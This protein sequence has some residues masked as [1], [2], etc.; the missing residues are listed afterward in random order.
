MIDFRYHL[1]SLISV[2]LALAVGIALGAGPLEESIGNTL[3]GQVD[4]LREERADLR[5]QLEQAEADLTRS[6][7]ALD[8]VSGDLLAEVMGQRRVALVQVA[9]VEP[10]VRDAVIARLEQA[11]ATVSA[12]VQV[13]DAW[14][15]PAELAFRQSLA[16]RLVEY[17]D[18][19]PAD[20]AGT[21]TELAEA[22]AQGLTAARPEDPDAVAESAAVVLELLRE[23]GLIEVAADVTAPADAVVVLAGPAVSAVQAEQEQEQADQETVEPEVLQQEDEL[24]ESRLGAAQQI[25]TAVQLRSAGAVVAGGDLVEPSLVQRLRADDATVGLVSTVESVQRVSGQV[26]VPLALA[27]RISGV[28]GHYGTSE[29][30]TDLMPPRV[31]LPPV[32]RVPQAPAEE[33]AAPDGG[34]EEPPTEGASTGDGGSTGDGEG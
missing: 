12:T 23:G 9:D 6:Q 30:A 3:T 8:D 20:D 1:V 13:T 17:L 25:S 29:S 34:V 16:G 5:E 19:R 2:F 27:A 7:A 14:T 22:L 28:V 24:R 31:V 10:E 21:G 4:Q 32:V 33:G 11:G 18:P 26:A 15:D